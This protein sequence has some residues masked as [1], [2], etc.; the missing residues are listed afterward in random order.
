MP[1]N[2]DWSCHMILYWF[3]NCH[4][5]LKFNKTHQQMKK[6]ESPLYSCLKCF[7]SMHECTNIN[8]LVL[9][10]SIPPCTH[11]VISCAASKQT[12]ILENEKCYSMIWCHCQWWLHDEKLKVSVCETEVGTWRWRFT[13]FNQYRFQHKPSHALSLITKLQSKTVTN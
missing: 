8:K 4:Y 9:S 2:I 12:S 3:C 6:I 10:L 1:L 13:L 11:T 5:T 7:F